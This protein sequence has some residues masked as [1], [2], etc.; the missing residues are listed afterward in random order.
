MSFERLAD[1]QPASDEGISLR[2][3]AVERAVNPW[4]AAGVIKAP[5]MDLTGPHTHHGSTISGPTG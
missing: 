4:E 2:G 5:I 3:G 1:C